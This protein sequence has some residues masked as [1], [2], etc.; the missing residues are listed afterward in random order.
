M[1]LFDSGGRFTRLVS[2][3]RPLVI[4]HRGASG[5]HPENTL[6]ALAEAIALHSDLIELDLRMSKDGHVVVI[7]DKTV[8]RTTDGKGDV[9]QLTLDDLRKLDA[10]FAFST[11]SGKTFPFRGQGI[12]VPTLEE[13]LT[14]FPEQLL[15]L[16]IKVASPRMI[17]QVIATLRR[18]KA[19]ER[20]SIELFSIPTKLAKLLRRLEPKLA[21]GHTRA[22]LVRFVA[23]AK[24]GIAWRF[25]RRAFAIEMPPRRNRVA[26]S[27]KRTLKAASLKGIPMFVWTVN[28]EI[29]M[30]RF[31][32]WGAAGLFTDH[33]KVLRQLVD[34]GAWD[35]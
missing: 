19:L 30:R 29:D 31:L 15:M 35:K 13:V 25:K 33:P 26:V 3:G 24:L 4:A 28:S 2:A 1:P 18:H 32:D 17:R 8:D 14:A 7:H 34:T 21:T 16:E 20:V 10:G 23:M 5:T 6:P 12:T 9:E 27:S 22:E 11:D